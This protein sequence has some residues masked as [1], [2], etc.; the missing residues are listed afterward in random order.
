MRAQ[1]NPNSA[2]RIWERATLAEGIS[3]FTVN[4]FVGRG[5]GDNRSSWVSRRVESYPMAVA[6]QA[7]TPRSAMYAVTLQGNTVHIDEGTPI[8]DYL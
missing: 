4:Q 5:N 7:I 6:L 1:D 3:H 2:A 8:G